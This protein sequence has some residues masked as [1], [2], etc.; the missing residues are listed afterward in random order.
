[1]QGAASGLS[2]ER[3]R[4]D[5]VVLLR[6]SSAEDLDQRLSLPGERPSFTLALPGLPALAPA[7]EINTVRLFVDRGL[8][9]VPFAAAVLLLAPPADGSSLAAAALRVRWSSL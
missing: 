1:M 9:A 2:C 4:G 3:L 7:P 6:G 5:E 8:V